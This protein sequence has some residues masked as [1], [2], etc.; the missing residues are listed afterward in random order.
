LLPFTLIF[1]GGATTYDSNFW[2]SVGWLVIPVSIV[3]VQLWLFLLK[4][5][6][7]RASLW[8]FL[9]PIFGLSYSTWLLDEP[10][11]WYTFAGTCLVMVSL[12]VGQRDVRAK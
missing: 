5:D 12:Y 2:L 4:E 8:L 3:A 7:V 1:E 11:T 10:F 9:C 6:A